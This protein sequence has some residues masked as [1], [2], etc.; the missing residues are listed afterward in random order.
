MA[1]SQTNYRT[2]RWVVLIVFMFAIALTQF[3]WLNFAPIETVVR[4][5]LNIDV[6]K[7]GLLTSIFPILSIILSAPV[8]SMLDAKGFRFTVSLGVIIMGI[9][10]L[11]RLT[12]KMHLAKNL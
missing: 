8:G 7:V 6:F 2:Y 4:Q 10:V 3:L 12:Q 1:K 5:Q 9:S 11:F